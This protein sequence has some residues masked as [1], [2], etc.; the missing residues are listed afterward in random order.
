MDLATNQTSAEPAL[1]ECSST[2]S[3]AGWAFWTLILGISAF[4]LFY[5]VTR[6]FVW[7]AGYHL[8][9][10][11]QISLGKLPYIDFCFPQTPL[12]AYLNAAVIKFFGQQ[13][14]PIHVVASLF[15]LGSTLLTAQYLLACFP[16]R[17][18]RLGCAITAGVFVGLNDVVVQFGTIGQAYGICLFFTV[19]AYRVAL[20]TPARVSIFPPLACGVLAG[21]AAGSSLLTAPILAT[22]LIWIFVYDRVGLP[23]RKAL[24][25]ICGTAIPFLPVAWLFSRGPEQTF[26]DIV[27]YHALYRRIDWPTSMAVHH[28]LLVFTSWLDSTQALTL[29]LLAAVGVVFIFKQSGWQR[30]QRAEFYLAAWISFAEGAYLCTPHPTFGRYFIFLTPFITIL[31]T[32]GLYALASKMGYAGRPLWPVA[33]ASGLMA[34]MFISW[35]I[36]SYD[37]TT[38]EEYEKVAKKVAEVTPPGGKIFA[39]EVVYFILQT[40]PPSGMECS[41]THALKLPPREE[42]LFHIVSE[43]ELKQQFE[44]HE[45]ATVQ[46]CS[47]PEMDR[48]GLPSSYR[49]KNDIDDCTVF[50]G[51]RPK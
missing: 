14:R 15:S 9:A 48:L 12:N 1:Q 33:L 44:Q 23:W 2:S 34:L 42:K 37:Q 50:W 11:T 10:A 21:I 51:T 32:A 39:D 26:F 24:A 22:I 47:D 25:F 28:D 46:S 20:A 5:A 43:P 16:A 17:N 29:I 19:A 8:M 27:K 45:F 30:S 35:D 18:W 41:Y 4:V 3:R 40:S 36:Q 38:W 13:W 31:S 6:A 7:D 49:Y